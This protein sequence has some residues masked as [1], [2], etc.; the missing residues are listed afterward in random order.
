LLK[1]P[2]NLTRSHTPLWKQGGARGIVEPYNKTPKPFSRQL[3]FK[4]TDAEQKLWQRLR[5]KQIHGVQ[6]YRQ[7]PLLHYIFDFYC[8]KASLVIE[9]DGSQHLE[10]EHQRTDALRDKA[11][12]G[13]GLQ[14]LRFDNHQVLTET[15]AVVE[16]IHEI[17]ER[18]LRQANP[19]NPPFSKGGLWMCYDFLRTYIEPP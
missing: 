10:A 19:P 4:L 11:L 8:A 14:V 15:D 3:R 2:T 9:L 5:R 12:A 7:K 6:F 13:Q 1:V 16:V 17:V 18:R